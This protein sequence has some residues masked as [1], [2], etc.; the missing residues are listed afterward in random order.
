MMKNWITSRF[1]Q[2]KWKHLFFTLLALNGLTLLLL[3]VFIVWPA[4]DQ[5][6]TLRSPVNEQESSEFIIRTTKG[7]LND[8]INAYLDQLLTGSPHQYSISLE[9][10]VHLKGE[11]PVFSTTVPLSARLEPIVQNNGDVV[12]K[13]RSIS[14]GLL[15]LPNKRIMQY[16]NNYFDVP[17]WVQINPNEEEVYL[18]ITTMQFESNFQIA[19][20]QIDLDA[21]NIAIKITIPYETLGIHSLPQ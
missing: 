7:N 21:N 18:A 20:E 16:M 9:E 2:I 10:D 15:E 17:E 19:A 4:T 13:L 5:D 6:R 1:K 3:I 8:L 14:I 12:L 11:L